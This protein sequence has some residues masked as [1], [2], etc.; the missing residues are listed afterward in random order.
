M[1][2]NKKKHYPPKN[3]LP[4]TS[5]G[6]HTVHSLPFRLRTSLSIC[7]ADSLSLREKCP[8]SEFFLSVFSHIR[9]EYGEILLISPYSVQMQENTDQKNSKYGHFLRSVCFVASR[10][11]TENSRTL[12]AGIWLF[13][14][15]W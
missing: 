7:F 2:A 13:K 4:K 8:Y 3:Y 6:S 12:K 5:L 1:I 11:F 10:V 14:A 15:S 9:T